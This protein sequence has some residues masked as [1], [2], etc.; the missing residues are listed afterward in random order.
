MPSRPISITPT[1]TPS[2][3]LTVFAATAQ[4]QQAVDGVWHGLLALASSQYV[5][6]QS[7]LSS[8]LSRICC[9]ERRRRAGMMMHAD[10]TCV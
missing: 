4:R 3:T 10:C 5:T 2:L 6:V 1:R 9:E 8:A 7:G